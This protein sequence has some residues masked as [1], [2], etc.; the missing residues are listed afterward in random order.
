MIQDMVFMA[1]LAAQETTGTMD[2][3]RSATQLLAELATDHPDHETFIVALVEGDGEAAPLHPALGVPLVPSS[4][5]A[6]IAGWLILTLSTR[7]HVDLVEAELVL[8]AALQPMPG[9]ALGAEAQEA[10]QQLL[11]EGARL[12]AS[13]GRKQF[14]VWHQQPLADS[15]TE[16]S[17]ADALG[18][19]G[20]APA[21]SEWTLAVELKDAPRA[22]AEG[23]NGQT[24][25]QTIIDANFPDALVPEVARVYE[26]ASRDIPH[27]H[28]PL[29]PEQWDAQ[30]LAANTANMRELGTQNVHVLATGADGVITAMAEAFL[31]SGNTSVI[32][33]GL[34]YVRPAERGRGLATAAG[35]RL[36]FAIKEH[37]PAVQRGYAAIAAEN[38]AALTLAR[39]YGG[40]E[41]SRTTAWVTPI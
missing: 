39:K 28:L 35:Q 24:T 9:E 13:V 16:A 14:V 30:R 37:F 2:A 4:A 40:R 41:I 36:A 23:D 31:P 3:S 17:W 33:L 38:T 5:D 20:F 22:S 15:A 21:Y 10:I 12:G 6:E 32:D 29:Q 26:A 8:D 25:W 1:N 34:L 11:T 18:R 7:D 19:L 27:G